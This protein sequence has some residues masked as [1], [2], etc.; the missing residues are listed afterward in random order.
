MDDV[1]IGSVFVFD[2]VR[3]EL[4]DV[5][6]EQRREVRHWRVRAPLHIHIRLRDMRR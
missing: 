4:R 5:H 1:V 6:D 3:G 2:S